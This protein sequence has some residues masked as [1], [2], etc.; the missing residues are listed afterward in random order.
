MKTGTGA[1]RLVHGSEPRRGAAV[2]S[3]SIEWHLWSVDRNEM[4]ATACCVW[5]ARCAHAVWVSRG[6]GP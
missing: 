6:A 5:A 3:R 2:I 4:G 1:V